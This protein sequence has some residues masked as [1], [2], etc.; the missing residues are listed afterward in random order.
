[1]IFDESGDRHQAIDV[2][3]DRLGEESL[4]TIHSAIRAILFT[5]VVFSV[6][7]SEAWAVHPDIR[8]GHIYNGPISLRGPSDTDVRSFG[9]AY[10]SGG[11]CTPAGCYIWAT[12]DSPWG[13]GGGGWGGGSGGDRLQQW[14]EW[15]AA[16]STGHS[17]FTASRSIET[18]LRSHS[19]RHAC[20]QIR[21]CAG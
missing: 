17:C 14:W 18:S 15:S 12:P 21:G 10:E 1:M 2:D 8:P 16:G 6:G 9:S 3:V 4:R 19:I 7:M 20:A 13:G 5:T 11:F